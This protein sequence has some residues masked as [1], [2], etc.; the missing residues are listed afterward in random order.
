MKKAARYRVVV[1]D[2][3]MPRD[4]RFLDRIGRYDPYQDPALIEID[5]EKAKKWLSK[6]AKPTSTVR[7]LFAKVGIEGG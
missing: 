4:G 2:E 1:Q 6:G 7:S 3:R 5:A